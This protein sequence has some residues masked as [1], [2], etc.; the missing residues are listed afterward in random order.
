MPLKDGPDAGV[1][2]IPARQQRSPGGTTDRAVGVPVG[3]ADAFSSHPVEVWRSEIGG[4]H[5]RQIAVPLVVRH[6]HD[7]VGSFIFV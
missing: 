4:A 6:E 2:R 7:D 5:A 1:A 3:E